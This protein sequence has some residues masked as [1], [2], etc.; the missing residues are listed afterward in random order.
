MRKKL[1]SVFLIFSLLCPSLFFVAC[2]KKETGTKAEPYTYSILLKNAKGKVDESLLPSE[3]DYDQLKEVS[4]ELDE[5]D[6]KLTTTKISNL[7]GELKISLLEGYDYSAL[8]FKV[9]NKTAEFDIKTKT[10][11]DAAREFSLTD[12]FFDYAY[13]NMNSETSLIIDFSD[14]SL[15]EVTIDVSDLKGKAKCKVMSNDFL[16]FDEAKNLSISYSSIASDEIT[17]EY[18]TVLAFDYLEPI[19]YSPENSAE[20]T[21]LN[22]ASFGSKFVIGD[23]KNKIQ[24][25]TA[26]EN[27]KC[28]KYL[29][30]N[31]A[32][33]YGSMRVPYSFNLNVATSLENLESGDYETPVIVS[34]QYG[35]EII[36]LEVYEGDTLFVDIEGNSDI[37]Y[38]L[39]SLDGKFSVTNKVND[40]KNNNYLQINLT[41]ENGEKLPTKYL[42]RNYNTFDGY[43]VYTDGLSSVSSVLNADYFFAGKN[44]PSFLSE[45][46]EDS[47]IDFGV[48]YGFKSSVDTSS[49]DLDLKVSQL[50]NEFIFE[51][52]IKNVK[53]GE[54][55]Y[56]PA[57]ES[58]ITVASSNLKAV[59]E[60]KLYA[61]KGEVTFEKFTKANIYVSIEDIGLYEGETLYY[62]TNLKDVASW[63]KYDVSQRNLFF[64]TDG[65]VL[66]Y[67]LDSPRAD[68]VLRFINSEKEQV[69]AGGNLVDC[70][71][72]RASGTI[73]VEGKV[74]WLEDVSHLEIKPAEYESGERFD[75]VRVYDTNYHSIVA[76]SGVNPDD[77]MV[78]VGTVSKT[79]FKK[80]SEFQNLQ[81]TSESD[82]STTVYYYVKSA[83]N[84]VIGLLDASGETVGVSE[85]Y[86]YESQPMQIDGNFVYKLTLNQMMFEEDEQFFATVNSQTYKVKEFEN[87][88]TTVQFYSDSARRNLVNGIAEGETYYFISSQLEAGKTFQIVD[89][90]GNI[91]VESSKFVEV[92]K[93]A[94]VN[95]YSVEF[96]FPDDVNYLPGTEFYLKIV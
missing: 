57:T 68:A 88:D 61:L 49:V 79:S 22:Y 35:S 58:E 96:G 20:L 37:Y 41:N 64:S 23:G 53:I 89:E 31:D 19:A 42:L 11:S 67:Y 28:E 16:T 15:A 54:T 27:G 25:L 9:N 65:T 95:I 4:F 73:E 82:Y 3:Y 78:A 63:K 36:T 44:L 46:K 83:T 26:K 50:Q 29:I 34:E 91:V 62:S 7:T 85:I 13:T 40:N 66:Y 59:G 81:I 87:Q 80:L 77:I 10:S 69:S 45:I 84:K 60:T 56:D 94:S 70:F 39:D 86:Y 93:L 33:F 51:T 12:R 18:G 75:L 21:T 71:G 47:S 2:K 38:L 5:N 43:Y 92:Q 48:V 8:R 55:N 76:A 24:Y 90:D 1:V 17:V 52:K 32:E 30:T 72:R 6:Y 74:I 14:C